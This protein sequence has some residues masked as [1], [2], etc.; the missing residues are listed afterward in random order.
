MNAL[1]DVKALPKSSVSDHVLDVSETLWGY[2]VSEAEDRFD[3]ETLMES[4]MRFVGLLLVVLAYGQW[5]L[6]GSMFGPSAFAMKAALTF[7]FGAGGATLYWFASRGSNSEV[8]FDTD[9][10]EVRIVSR[11]AKDQT[12]LL[13]SMK[14]DRIESAFTVCPKEPGAMAGLFL[15]LKGQSTPMHLFDG[16]EHEIR[17]LHQRIVHDMLPA[18]ERLKA[19]IARELDI[20][21]AVAVD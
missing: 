4:A 17:A 3:R 2:I 21:A 1:S 20:P 16:E 19:R 14:M 5:L 11:N 8:H 18:Q 15:R 6:P 9:K 12:R 13:S 10:R 7:V